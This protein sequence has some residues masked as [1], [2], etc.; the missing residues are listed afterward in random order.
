MPQAIVSV[1]SAELNFKKVFG[2]FMKFKICLN[3]FGDIFF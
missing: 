1:L 3:L 2:L